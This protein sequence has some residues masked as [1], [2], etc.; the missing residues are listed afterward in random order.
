M[1]TDEGAMKKLGSFEE[2]NSIAV[3]D[4]IACSLTQPR[5]AAISAVL[6]VYEKS[7]ENSLIVET[8]L[9]RGPAEY[10][11]SLLGQYEH[12]RD[13]LLFSPQEAG[14]DRLWIIKTTQSFGSVAMAVRQQRLTPLTARIEK[15]SVQ[16]WL[17]DP[18][19]KAGQQPRELATRLGA[20]ASFED[21]S[22]ELLGD[23][24]DHAKAEAVY[25]A[26]IHAFEE[27]SPTRFSSLLSSRAW[28]KATARTCSTELPR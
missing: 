16:I 7:S 5:R 2:A 25:Q 14:P 22:T 12:Q 10:L 11:A 23:E 3:A 8:S 9:E 15:T 13:V 17:V 28:Q 27:H 24:G 21:G 6:G 20:S 18:G 4:R 26:K 19:G 1:L